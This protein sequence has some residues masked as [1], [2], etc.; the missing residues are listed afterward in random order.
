MRRYSLPARATLRHPLIVHQ[1][2]ISDNT[3]SD[4]FC[5][6]GAVSAFPPPCKAIASMRMRALP[7]A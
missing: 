1:S 6:S 2:H 7:S 5:K 3:S 4:V